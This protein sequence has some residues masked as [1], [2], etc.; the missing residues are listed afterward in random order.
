ML[1]THKMVLLIYI[2]TVN[3]VSVFHRILD[4]N[5]VGCLFRPPFFALGLLLLMRFAPLDTA[6]NLL[7]ELIGRA[8]VMQRNTLSLIF[9]PEQ[10]FQK[11]IKQR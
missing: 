8:I 10:M 1:Y 5:G 2:P 9:Y 11:V 7:R 4:L 6:K 3:F